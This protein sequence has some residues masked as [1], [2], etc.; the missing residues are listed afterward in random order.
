MVFDFGVSERNS[1][2]VSSNGCCGGG[3][4]GGGCGARVNLVE[5]GG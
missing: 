2:T 1:F 3:G 4:G 5:G